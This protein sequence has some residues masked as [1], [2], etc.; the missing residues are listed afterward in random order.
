MKPEVSWTLGCLV[1]A[2]A[3]VG[4]LIL[5]LLVTLALQPPEWAQVVVGIGLVAGGAVLAWLVASA[6]G[7]SR[8][9]DR[10]RKRDEGPSSFRK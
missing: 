4:V 8:S 9:R 3:L 10:T 2:A 6:L 1:G 5:V 7:R